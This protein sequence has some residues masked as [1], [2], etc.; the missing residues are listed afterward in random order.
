MKTRNLQAAP[1]P[2]GLISTIKAGFDT[3]TNH[4]SLIV[5]AVALD[6]FLWFGPHL[7]LRN[8]ILDLLSQPAFASGAAGQDSE[9]IISLSREYWMPFAERFN[10]LTAL[11]SYP[12]GIPSL[13]VSRMPLNVPTGAAATV[14]VKS[15]L[16]AIGLWLL[17]SLLGL[18][19][20]ALYFTLVAQAVNGK[21]DWRE[22]F[23]QWPW[24][25][26]QSILLAIFWTAL[27]LML[28]F[29][30]SCLITFLSLAGGLPLG[31][32]GIALYAGIMIW[33]LFPLLLSPHGIFLNRWKM[34]TSLK[35]GFRLTRKT[36]P[37]TAV[38]FLIVLV[39]SEGLDLVWM[40]PPESSWM[41]LIGVIGH[42]F[43]T[44]GLL[45]ATFVYYRDASR[46]VQRVEQQIKFL[47]S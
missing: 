1:A 14:E 5:F 6:L 15:F 10:I 7:R 32:L 16:A 8:L 4:F 39:I 40:V 13:M 45:A 23:F 24:T 26:T 18:A 41:A 9:N 36:L 30:L 42:A 12:V 17:F 33:V 35:E 47:S 20:G 38:L 21:V 37:G 43:V 34:W 29:P 3:I 46:W 44:T 2:P 22:A 27:L 11:R 19:A 31:Q 25:A 28:S